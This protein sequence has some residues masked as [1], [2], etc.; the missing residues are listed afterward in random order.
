MYLSIV[1]LVCDKDIQYLNECISFIK[2]RVKLTNEIIL[3]DN[4]ND[5]KNKIEIEGVKVYS[6]GKNIGVYDGRLWATQY[7]SG[8]YVWFVDVDDEVLEVPSYIGGLDGDIIN[9]N[10]L[11]RQNDILSS[12]ETIILKNMLIKETSQNFVIDE[13]KA[14]LFWK[15][16][17]APLWS[18][19]IKTELIQK[20][21]KMLPENKNYQYSVDVH[22]LAVAFDNAKKISFYKNNLYIYNVDRSMGYNENT[23]YEKLTYLFDNYKDMEIV[24]KGVLGNKYYDYISL[25]DDCYFS[26]WFVDNFKNQKDKPK[27]YKYICDLFG[28]EIIKEIVTNKNY[29]DVNNISKKFG[30]YIQELVPYPQKWETKK[31][32]ILNDIEREFDKTKEYKN[33]EK[34]FLSVVITL[35]DRDVDVISDLLLRIRNVI[36]CEHEI[37][38]VD[39]RENKKDVLFNTY[40]AEIIS[41][42]RNLYIFESRRYAAEFCKGEYLYFVDADDFVLSVDVDFTKIKGKDL[43]LFDYVEK[44]NTLTEWDK[45]DRRVIEYNGLYSSISKN[46]ISNYLLKKMYGVSLW[47]K[48]IRTDLFKSVAEKMPI[49]KD[50]IF[51]ED[52]IWTTCIFNQINSIIAIDSPIYIHNTKTGITSNSFTDFNTIQKLLLGVNDARSIIDELLVEDSKEIYGN[53]FELLIPELESIMEVSELDKSL[54][55]IM[56]YYSKEDILFGLISFYRNYGMAQFS[57]IY[58]LIVPKYTNKNITCGVLF[59]ERDQDYVLSLVE[60]LNE[61]F[62]VIVWDD[63]DDKSKKIKFPVNVTVLNEDGYKH[64]AYYARRKVIEATETEF[65]WFVDADDDFNTNIYIDTAYDVNAYSLRYIYDES[66]KNYKDYVLQNCEYRGVLWNDINSHINT[67]IIGTLCNK[68]IKTS[69]YKKAISV[70]PEYDNISAEEDTLLFAAVRKFATSMRTHPDILYLYHSYRGRVGLINY[71]NKV[72]MFRSA[73]KGLKKFPE[74]ITLLGDETELKKAG[75]E[76]YEGILGF[77]NKRIAIQDKTSLKKELIKLLENEIGTDMMRIVIDTYFPIILNTCIEIVK[78]YPPRQEFLVDDKPTVFK[79]VVTDDSISWIPD[80]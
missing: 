75:Y 19:W 50:I 26:I 39:N 15:L 31:N 70:L 8:K 33:S 14:K 77:I 29:P 65:L 11:N 61:R 42:G 60:K 66:C 68:I 44:N 6:K 57:K 41:K 13:Y 25:K 24:F 76:K 27:G 9:F 67:A 4:R 16:L 30:E 74:I 64:M 46:N 54:N 79:C 48:W 28:S 32:I 52:E 22:T 49:D 43:I 72:D 58:S 63:R 12:D 59:Y 69:I 78:E 56:K 35:I 3:I 2:E 17:K 47:N 38:I 73:I 51:C 62:S 40:G 5:Q 36:N 10:T 23:S 34:P 21:A 80:M 7:C 37:I 45:T 1:V 55:E 18:N 71:T 53:V 20:V